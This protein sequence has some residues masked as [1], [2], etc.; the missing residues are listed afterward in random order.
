[1]ITLKSLSYFND[2]NEAWSQRQQFIDP[3]YALGGDNT[4]LGNVPA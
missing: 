1:M 3:A 4:E 2:L